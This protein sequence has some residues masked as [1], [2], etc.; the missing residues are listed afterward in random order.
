[1]LRTR[2]PTV[3][4]DW[5]HEPRLR[6]ARAPTAGAAGSSAAVE[7]GDTDSPFGVLIV[8]FRT[9]ARIHPDCVP[10]LQA[11]RMCSPTRCSAVRPRAQIRRQG[12]HDPLT[13][14][15]NRGLFLDRVEHALERSRED[16]ARWPC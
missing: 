9:P 10:F 2:N 5:E 6:G 7:V 8:N 3:V 14:L 11:L 13:G 12:L 1:V 4:E 15:A 16:G